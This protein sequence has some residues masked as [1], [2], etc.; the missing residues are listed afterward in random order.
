VAVREGNH[1]LG[2]HA[3]DPDKHPVAIRYLEDPHVPGAQLE[4]SPDGKK[5]TVNDEIRS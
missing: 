4:I 5:Y 3:C 2:V 1:V